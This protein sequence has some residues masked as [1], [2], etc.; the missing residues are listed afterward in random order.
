MKHLTSKEEAA[1]KLREVSK[2]IPVHEVKSKKELKE[3]FDK[4]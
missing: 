1:A 2:K 4:D 3:F